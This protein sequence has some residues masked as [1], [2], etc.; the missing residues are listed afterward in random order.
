MVNVAGRS[1][2]C[3][4]CRR[5]KVKCDQTRPLCARCA[6]SNLYCD[7]AR[8]IVFINAGAVKARSSAKGALE[9]V[10]D[11]RSVRS[12]TPPIV[13]QVQPTSD[14][15]LE[16][17]ICFGRKF[18]RSGASIDLALQGCTLDDFLAEGSGRVFLQALL[19]FSMLT[20]GSEHG[21]QSL[22]TEGHAVHVNALGELN[23]AL[24]DPTR[25]CD[26]DVLL[27]VAVLAIQSSVVPMGESPRAYLQHMLGL[28]R[29]LG[30][31]DPTIHNSASAVNLYSSVRHFVLFAALRVGKASLLARP[32]WKSVLRLGCSASEEHEHD[33]WDILA[34]CTVLVARSNLVIAKSGIEPRASITQRKEVEQTSL[35]LLQQLQVWKDRWMKDSKNHYRASVSA[36]T[37]IES[38]SGVDEEDWSSFATP[39]DFADRSAAPMLML[40]NTALIHVLQVLSALPVAEFG[41]FSDLVFEG[42]SLPS[43]LGAKR[44][45]S[46]ERGLAIR[47]AALEICNCVPA[48][49][50]A[51]S[52]SGANIT[53]IFHWA[54][55]TAWIALR[56]DESSEGGWMRSLLK[57]AEPHF[58]ARGLM[59]E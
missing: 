3:S 4:T 2:G 28:E 26:D 7:G 43:G 13:Q 55:S 51:Q 56:G 38:S 35:N 27:A 23:R 57:N 37:K 39:L 45:T 6:R 10:R 44:M 33:L 48:Y 52:L 29:L 20:F 41:V 50:Q 1:K 54:T 24:S 32:E 17:Y 19:G 25:R 5:R 58:I 53:P 31:R 8:D 46:K 34:D 42:N 14:A 21:Q 16:R 22:V 40:Y 18:F 59:T 36:E 12:T 15:R 9:V 30:L 11:A 49:F 47:A